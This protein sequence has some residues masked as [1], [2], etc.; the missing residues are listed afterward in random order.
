MLLNI[1]P[2]RPLAWREAYNRHESAQQSN[3]SR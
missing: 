3:R 2:S 1:F